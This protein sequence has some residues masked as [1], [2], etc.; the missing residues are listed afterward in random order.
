MS[1]ANTL[2]QYLAEHGVAY[3][4]LPH[5]HASTSINSAQ[6]AHIPAEQLAKSVIL[7]DETGYIMAVVPASRHVKIGRLNHA[8]QRR[9][10]LATEEELGQLFPDCEV[11]AIPPIGEAYGLTTIVDNSLDDCSDIYFEAGDHLQ[12][13]HVKGTTFKKIMKHSQH[14]SFCM[15]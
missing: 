12:L 15:H 5:R 14:G 8:L 4:I 7:E 1:I 13:I 6:S 2:L 9:M 10:G 3:D 11:G